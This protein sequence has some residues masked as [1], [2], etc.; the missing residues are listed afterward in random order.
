MAFICTVSSTEGESAITTQPEG[1]SGIFSWNP[2]YLLDGEEKNVTISAISSSEDG[3]EMI[4]EF[5][6]NYGNGEYILHD[7]RLGIDGIYEFPMSLW[8]LYVLIGIGVL[9]VGTFGLTMSKEEYREYL[10]NRILYR[11][12][13]LHQLTVEQVLENKFRQK[14]IDLI[15]DQPGIHYRE[16][17]RQVGTSASNLTWHLEVLVNYKIIHKQLVGKYLIY[18]PYLDKNPFADFD[19]TLVKSKTTLN[20]YQL[21]GDNPGIYQN[22]IANRMGLNHNTIKYHLEKLLDAKLIYIEQVGRKKQYHVIF[23]KDEIVDNEE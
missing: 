12:K 13:K 6:L 22:K 11:E 19:P 16:L 4:S 8:W 5:Y 1:A 7:P 18:Y 10:I 2:T 9:I 20:I 15:I 3:S 17:L 23:E 14:I 21:I